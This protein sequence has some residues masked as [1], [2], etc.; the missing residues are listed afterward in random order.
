MPKKKPV[1]RT[2][3]TI[4]KHLVEISVVPTQFG[5]CAEWSCLEPYCSGATNPEQDVDSAVSSA[6]VKASI[7]IGFRLEELKKEERDNS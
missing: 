6:E 3:K 2:S 4:Q 5:F 7:R 1:Y